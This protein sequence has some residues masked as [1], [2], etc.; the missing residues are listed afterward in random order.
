MW[1][2]YLPYDCRNLKS[3]LAF[4][5]KPYVHMGRNFHQLTPYKYSTE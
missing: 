1:V 4:R 5:S 3:M 2:R